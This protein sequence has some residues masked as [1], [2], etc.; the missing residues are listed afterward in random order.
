M[1]CEPLSVATGAH[2]L[3]CERTI[4]V[5]YRSLRDLFDMILDPAMQAGNGDKFA[6]LEHTEVFIVRP[7]ISFVQVRILVGLLLAV[8]ALAG[9]L[10][11][12]RRGR[13]D[14]LNVP[15]KES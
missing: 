2:S 11:I 7:M 13:R 4:S 14:V 15:T 5:R 9:L 8:V 12:G 6:S 1:P 10:V 3:T